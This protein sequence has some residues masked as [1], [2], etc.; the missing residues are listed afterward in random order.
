MTIALL[1]YGILPSLIFLGFIGLFVFL[2]SAD[3]VIW[4]KARKVRKTEK[5]PSPSV[6]IE[7]FKEC[8]L[9]SSMQMC[10]SRRRI[11]FPT[12]KADTFVGRAKYFWKINN[13][14]ISDDEEVFNL[15]WSEEGW[16]L[17]TMAEIDEYYEYVKEVFDKRIIEMPIKEV[18]Q[19][20]G[21]MIAI[22]YCTKEQ[23]RLSTSNM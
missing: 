12:I 6:S 11:A 1:I 18:C 22:C 20:Q 19:C 8:L 14:I 2:F 5:T 13:K 17:Y 10:S 4:W 9:R 21:G 16:L 15:M 7:V 3:I 23:R